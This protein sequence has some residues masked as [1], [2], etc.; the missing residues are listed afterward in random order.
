MAAPRTP[1]T[2]RRFTLGDPVDHLIGTAIGWGG[3]PRS[4][5]DY[6]S[7][8]PPQNDGRTAYTLTVKDVPVDGFWSITLYN[9]KGYTEKNDLDRYSLNNL[10]A[11]PNPDGTYTIHFGGPRDAANYLPIMPGWNY[12]VRLYRPRKEVI[13]GTWKFPGAQPVR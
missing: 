11:K 4:A 2:P 13:D 8:Y 9:A 3:N 12:T 6:Q 1:R 7:F 5:A 10:T